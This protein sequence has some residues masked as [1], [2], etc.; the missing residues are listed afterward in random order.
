[1]NDDSLDRNQGEQLFRVSAFGDH[2][3]AGSH[4]RTLHGL[5]M[6]A[7]AIGGVTNPALNPLNEIGIPVA[8]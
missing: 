2:G 7:V 6:T 4:D 3:S 1:M 5:S 8:D